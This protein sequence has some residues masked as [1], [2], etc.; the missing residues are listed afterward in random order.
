MGRKI[1][2]E[3]IN[4]GFLDAPRRYLPLAPDIR[5]CI[6]CKKKTE[7]RFNHSTKYPENERPIISRTWSCLECGYIESLKED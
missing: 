5:W 3:V 6:K 2:Q 7:Q 1:N 4:M